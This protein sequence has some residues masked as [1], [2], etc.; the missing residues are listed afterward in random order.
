[1]Y[2]PVPILNRECTKEYKIPGTEVIIEKG[3]AVIIPAMA[4]QTDEKYYPEPMTFQPE[5]F[6]D[7][8]NKSFSFKPYMPF[9]EG[10]RVCIGTRMGKLQTKVGLVTM[11]QYHNYALAP[12]LI[13][14]TLEMH[15][16]GFVPTARNGIKLV[17]TPR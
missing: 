5:R 11:L 2:P 17:A 4:L 16:A 13:G 9:G 15:P 12:E 3:T 10:P 14:K 8:K 7:E 1:M 6:L